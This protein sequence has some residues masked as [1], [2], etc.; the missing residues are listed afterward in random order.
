MGFREKMAERMMGQMSAEERQAMMDGM[1]ENFMSGMSA[2]E[3]QKVMETMMDR[4]MGGMSDSEKRSMMSSMMPGMMGGGS[5]GG[6]MG[7]MSAMMGGGK[8]EGEEGGM[9]FDMCRKMMAGMTRASE[10]ASYATPELRGLFEEWVAQIEDEILAA[11][12]EAGSPDVAALAARFKL[13][14]ESVAYILNRLA[15]KGKINLKAEK[16]G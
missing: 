7:M 9:P 11:V 15:T 10:L 1:M 6:M 4:F 2:G 8:T 5:G 16:K 13:S 14:P 12:A 3:R